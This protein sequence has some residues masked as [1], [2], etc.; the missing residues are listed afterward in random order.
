MDG[1]TDGWTDRQMDQ[2]M[3]GQTDGQMNK[4]T[5]G[6][7]H[8]WT[9]GQMDRWKEMLTNGQSHESATKEKKKTSSQATPLGLFCKEKSQRTEVISGQDLVCTGQDV[10]IL[11]HVLVILGR[12]RSF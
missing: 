1:R 7:M 8:K 6:R 5:E 2:Q 12:P 4:Q 9:D 10:I 3:D 11:V